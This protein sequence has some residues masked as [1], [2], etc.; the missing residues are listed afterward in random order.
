MVSTE[1]SKVRSLV[2]TMQRDVYWR[3]R[4][5]RGLRR[6]ET[7]QINLHPAPS[8]SFLRPDFRPAENGVD[9]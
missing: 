9:S 1:Y 7:N 4:V 6:T 2:E 5:M 8:S 3:R